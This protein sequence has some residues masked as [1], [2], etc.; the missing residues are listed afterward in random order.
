MDKLIE[1]LE[2]INPDIDYM[3]CDDLIYGHLLDSLSII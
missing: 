2:D 3:T 1:I